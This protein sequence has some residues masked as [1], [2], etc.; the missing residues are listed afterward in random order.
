[1]NATELLLEGK[2][3]AIALIHDRQAM[4]Y[5]AL[6]SLCRHSAGTWQELGI[7]PGQ[8]CVVALPDGIDW[9][10]AFIGLIWA[11]GQ[12]IAVNP[13]TATDQLG[14]LVRDSGATVLLLEDMAAAAFGAGAIALSDWQTR[15]ADCQHAPNAVQAS[16]DSPAFILYSSGTTGTPKG[17]IHAHRAIR[18]AHVFARDML[19][20]SAA[21]RFYS[22]SKLFFA[23]PLANAFFA[24]LRLGAS[25]I[26]D[27]GWPDPARVAENVARHRPTLFFSVPTL[28]RRLL[29]AGVS[30]DSLR[31][32]VS[33]GEACPPALAQ[34]W[35]AHTGAELV[36]GY[37]TTETLSLMLYRRQSMG[38]ARATP[39]TRVTEETTPDSE[40]GTLRLWFDHPAVALGY[41]RQ[42]THDNARFGMHGFS[43]G[44]LFRKANDDEGWLFAG[45]TDQLVKV[46]GRWVDIVAV[47]DIL[48]HA[49]QEHLGE[50]CIVPCRA[51]DAD[52]ICLHLFIVPA[53]SCDAATLAADAARA[54]EALPPYQRPCELH[55]VEGFPRTD[56]GKL[57]RAELASQLA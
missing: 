29:Q 16:P 48:Q 19:G 27:S 6:R 35:A 56:T 21:D 9:A 10:V 20:A 51:N 26:L 28:L 5:A 42:V 4:S 13:R 14:G 46:F 34:D 7:R 32:S 39:L 25:V 31:A 37:G 12:P 1:M 47:E 45:R 41:S 33:A 50:L 43:P 8:R 23:Y 57:K 36:N 52:L 53:R 2:P 55:L 24:G 3:D 18:D 11:G 40:S 22:T 17:I 30:F 49:L 15:L 44:D 54:F 38:V